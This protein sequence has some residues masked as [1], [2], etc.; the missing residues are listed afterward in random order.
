VPSSVSRHSA[1]QCAGPPGSLPGGHGVP[2]A[3]S[4]SPPASP[5]PIR[6]RPGVH[7]QPHSAW[8]TLA[9]A[10]WQTAKNRCRGVAAAL[11]VGR[12]AAAATGSRTVTVVASRGRAPG[13]TGNFKFKLNLKAHAPHAPCA[14]P[15]PVPDTLPLSLRRH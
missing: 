1:A 5:S 14:Q 9:A 3:P 6:A 13:A 10:G 2:V 7:A 8:Q 4:Q 15:V 11:P 12:G